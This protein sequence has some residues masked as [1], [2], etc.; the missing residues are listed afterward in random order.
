MGCCQCHSHKFDPFTQREYYQLF[1]FFNQT[2]D[3]NRYDQEPLLPTPS[4][5]QKELKADLERQLETAKRDYDALAASLNNTQREWEEAVARDVPWRP[6][7]P[8]KVTSQG[9]ATCTVLDDGSVLVSGERP[10]VDTYTIEASNDAGRITALRLETLPDKSLPAGRAGRADDGGFAVSKVQVLQEPIRPAENV[11]YVRVELPRHDYLTMS[12]VQVFRGDEN[13]ALRKPARQSSTAYEGW[14]ELA[15]DG[16]T[17]PHFATGRS[18]SHTAFNDNPWWEV[19][20]GEPTRVDRI[21][22]WNEDAHPKRLAGARVT[23]FDSERKPVWQHTLRF[24]PDLTATLTVDDVLPQFA[25][26]GADSERKEFPAHHAIESHDPT[27]HG[28]SPDPGATGSQ[29]LVLGLDQPVGADNSYQLKIIVDQQVKLAGKPGQT[30]GHFRLLTT[31][32][33]IAARTATVPP[34]IRTIAKTPADKRT[35]AEAEEITK[36]YRSLVQEDLQRRFTE[37]LKPDKTPIMVELPADKQR[38]THLFVRGSFLNPGEVVTADTPAALPAFPADATRNRLGLARWLIDPKNP[39]TARVVANRQWEQ[40]F[41]TG[42]VLTSEDFG[43]Q[44]M[45]PSHP[46]LLDWLAVELRDNRWS[47]KRLTKTIVMSATY[48]QSSRVTPEK[49]ARDPANRLISRGPRVRLSAEQIRD[50]AL[51]VS[52]LLSRKIGG[53]SVMPPQPDGVW[54]VVYSDDRW[55]ASQGE[56]RYRRGL[57]TFWRR[58]S[59]YPSAMALDAT[60]RET[61]TIR[62]VTTNT[63]I[64]AF[65]LLN[66]PAYIEAAQA[67]ARRVM[68]SKEA[69]PA[70]RAT[71]AFRRVLG[72]PPKPEEVERLVTLHN[73]EL[74]HYKQAAKD[75]TEMATSELGPPKSKDDVAELAA[76]TVVSNVLLNLDETLNN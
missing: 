15:V 46:E 38:T 13:V 24:S 45:L 8:T 16:S 73:T 61:C 72:R 29:S 39:L 53:P 36:Y 37:E 70:A 68:E 1:A 42:L 63:P 62:R 51:A 66:D 7:R 9:G 2:A 5:K 3:A 57:Y 44:G 40:L 60:S 75:A 41:G 54:Q 56:D 32:N 58:T 17:H 50:Q 48:R 49:L 23:C 21:V 20:L 12:E 64:A 55:I 74:E 31:D 27:Q 14:A 71:Y 67:L 6:L 19:D 30:L 35:P 47:L 25:W 28:W 33:P 18:I 59:P 34:S 69:E 22:L 10:E 52:G 65:A 26:A 43:S 76:W 4:A 11:K